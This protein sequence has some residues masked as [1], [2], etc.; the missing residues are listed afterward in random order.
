MEDFFFAGGWLDDLLTERAAPVK[1]TE[2]VREHLQALEQDGEGEWA[3]D[4][5]VIGDLLHGGLVGEALERAMQSLG[6]VLEELEGSA[7]KDRVVLEKSFSPSLIRSSEIR[8]LLHPIEDLE[9]LVV[10]RDDLD[11]VISLEMINDARRLLTSWGA[12]VWSQEALAC[13]P[14]L[15]GDLKELRACQSDFLDDEE[16]LSVDLD[17]KEVEMADKLAS[18]ATRF[19]R[20]LFDLHLLNARNPEVRIRFG[21]LWETVRHLEEGRNAPAAAFEALQVLEEALNLAGLRGGE[22]LGRVDL[23]YER[24]S[25]A[26]ELRRAVDHLVTVSRDGEGIIS[27]D[28]ARSYIRCIAQALGDLGLELNQ[29]VK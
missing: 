1:V 4:W 18:L 26:E 13:L 28:Q 24:F 7:V 25:D 3:E 2:K 19:A 27:G 22:L 11:A 14:R 8:K 9:E 17:E 6:R 23:L 12:A 29:T 20:D 15:E 5:S 16:T 10:S 21:L